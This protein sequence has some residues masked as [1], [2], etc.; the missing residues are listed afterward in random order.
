M[1]VKYVKGTEFVHEK[2]AG[3]KNLEELWDGEI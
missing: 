3:Y 1:Q 2:S